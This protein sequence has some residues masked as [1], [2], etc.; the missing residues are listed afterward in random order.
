LEVERKIGSTSVLGKG[1]VGIVVLG[2]LGRKKDAVKIRRSDSPRKNLIRLLYS[3]TLLI[4][5]G[6]LELQFQ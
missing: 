6:I 3:L 5:I 2:K 1:Y 4:T